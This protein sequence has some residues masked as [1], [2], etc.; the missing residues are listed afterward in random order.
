MKRVLIVFIAVL[1]M[2]L[3]ACRKNQEPVQSGSLNE[4]VIKQ[5]K[6]ELEQEEN[7]SEEIKEEDRKDEAEQQEDRNKS[8]LLL[9]NMSDDVSIEEVMSVL[10][11]SLEDKSVE[12]FIK[13]VRDYNETIEKKSLHDKFEMIEQPDYD[14]IKIGE[15]WTAKKGDFIGTNCRINTFMLLKDDIEMKKGAIDDSLLFL[16]QDAIDT[17]KLFNEEETERFKQ[18]FSK[19][20]TEATKD[21][22]VHAK[23]MQEHFSNIKFDDKVRVVS[24]VLHD[25]LDGDSLFIGHAGVLAENNGSY[26][27]VEKLSFEEPFQAIKFDKKEDCYDYLYLKYKHFHD[28]TTA[29]PF[30]M[31]NGDFIEL[32]LYDKE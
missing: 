21:I 26:L 30:I 17:G 6:E 9:S 32:E 2:F 4:H 12:D 18:F 22:R 24:V 8:K 14:L 25:N 1:S 29:K 16:D 3:T 19:V 10:K 27:F 15:L 28:D 31:D 5:E 11:A 7:P 23:K 20:N 13:G